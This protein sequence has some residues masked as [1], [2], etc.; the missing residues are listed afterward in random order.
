MLLLK[1]LFSSLV[2]YGKVTTTERKARTLKSHAQKQLAGY[3]KLSESR[4]QKRWVNENVSTVTFRK[5]VTANLERVKTEAKVSM[6][7]TAPQKGDNAAQYEV[8]I[9]NFDAKKNEQDNNA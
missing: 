2:I 6:V 8:S 9:L 3:G 4:M 1:N 5:R 7:R